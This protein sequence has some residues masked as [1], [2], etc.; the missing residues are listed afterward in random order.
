MDDFAAR[1][2][3]KVKAGLSFINCGQEEFAKKIQ[4]AYDN[5]ESVQL[6]DGYAPFCKHLFVKNFTDTLPTF[7]KITPENE[8]FI[9]SGYEAR[10][11][12]ELAVL[13][14]WFDINLMPEGSIK[15]AEYLDIILYSKEQIIKENEAPGSQDANKDLEYD[16]GIISIKAQDENRELPMQPITSMRNSLG[17]EYGGSGVPM[18]FEKYKESVDFWQKHA[19][20]K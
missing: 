3:D 12:N 18:D 20:I 16:Y 7:I 5:D 9:R 1:Q 15:K 11:E 17:K 10:R 4:D 19:T 6:I 8:T 13:A 14:R 2:F